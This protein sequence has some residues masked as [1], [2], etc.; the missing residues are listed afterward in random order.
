M[1]EREERKSQGVNIGRDGVG[2]RE[3]NSDRWADDRDGFSAPSKSRRLR[4]RDEDKDV[5]S[6]WEEMKEN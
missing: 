1:A 5:T 6:E 2:G 4:Q 3:R